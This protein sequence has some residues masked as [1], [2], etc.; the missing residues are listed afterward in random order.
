[1]ESISKILPKKVTY[2]N[3]EEEKTQ[4]DANIPPPIIEISESYEEEEEEEQICGNDSGIASEESLSSDS[5]NDDYEEEE[6]ENAQTEEIWKEIPSN[7]KYEQF[8]MIFDETI[9]GPI[10]GFSAYTPA[11]IFCSFITNEL[12]QIICDQTNLYASQCLTKKKD[13]LES[14]PHSRWNR[15]KNLT[16]NEFKNISWITNSYEHCKHEKFIR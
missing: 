5:L 12:I 11:E 7:Y 15:W 16:I 9:K 4:R 2:L 10:S 13:Y 1:M 6:K 8:N 3:Y 14:H